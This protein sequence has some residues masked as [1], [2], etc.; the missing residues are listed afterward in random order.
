M[1]TSA[2]TPPS[3]ARFDSLK[4][5]LAD[6]SFLFLGGGNPI[7]LIPS[8]LLL[9]LNHNNGII[10]DAF[11]HA[12]ALLSDSNATRLCFEGEKD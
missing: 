11:K 2:L 6:Q 8:G 10:F 12:G 4:I 1:G 9:V 7:H 5:Q 3:L